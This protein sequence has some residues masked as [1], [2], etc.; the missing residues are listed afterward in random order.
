MN[1]CYCRLLDGKRRKLKEDLEVREKEA[2]FQELYDKK[3][4]EQKLQQEIDRLRKEGSQQLEVKNFQ[5]LTMLKAE[6]WIGSAWIRIDLAVLDPKPYWECGFC[7]RS[8]F[9]EQNSK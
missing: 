6:L 1:F 9:I 7:S 3:T 8:V 5:D 2:R 4:S